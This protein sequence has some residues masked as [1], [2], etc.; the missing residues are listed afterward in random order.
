VLPLRNPLKGV[1]LGIADHAPVVAG[2]QLEGGT[3]DWAECRYAQSVGQ[4]AI[5]RFVP[6]QAAQIDSPMAG[7]TRRHRRCR[8]SL[9]F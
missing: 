6:Q 3:L 5:R 2:R 9:H 4:F 1:E 7:K 8:Q